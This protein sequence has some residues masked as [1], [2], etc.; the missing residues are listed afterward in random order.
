MT[1]FCTM[2][3][4][5]HEGS[6]SRF[7]GFLIIVGYLLFAGWIVVK[8]TVIPDIPGNLLMLVVGL[9]GINRLAAAIEAKYAAAAPPIAQG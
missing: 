1:F 4:E 8:T 9:Y 3:S 2:L 7:S 6:F 5:G